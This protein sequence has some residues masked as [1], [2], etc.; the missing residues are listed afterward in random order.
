MHAWRIRAFVVKEAMY[1]GGTD[2]EASKEAEIRAGSSH[3]GSE[4]AQGVP[5]CEVE[6]VVPCLNG[7]PHRDSCLGDGEVKGG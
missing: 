7:K 2:S 5:Q 4:E 1:G 6:L 3:L